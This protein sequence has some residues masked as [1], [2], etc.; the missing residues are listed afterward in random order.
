MQKSAQASGWFFFQGETEKPIYDKIF[1]IIL[2]WGLIQTINM[3]MQNF[4]FQILRVLKN[5][6]NCEDCLTGI[7]YFAYIYFWLS[8]WSR[9]WISI[10]SCFSSGKYHLQCVILTILLVAC[11]S[12]ELLPLICSCLW[13]VL[14]LLVSLSNVGS[15]VSYW[16]HKPHR[17]NSNQRIVYSL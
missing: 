8:S 9:F 14:S 10:R 11:Y 17:L 1:Q 12:H 2:F 3:I 16:C 15:V 7:T 13:N 5:L 4:T 6:L